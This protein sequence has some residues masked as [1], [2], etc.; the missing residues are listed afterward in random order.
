MQHVGYGLKISVQ[1]KSSGLSVSPLSNFCTMY[2]MHTSDRYRLASVG[3]IKQV[4]AIS[5]K[6]WCISKKVSTCHMGVV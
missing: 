2:G 1:L 4:G 6:G 5:R 3:E